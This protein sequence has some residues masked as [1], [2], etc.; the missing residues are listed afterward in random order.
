MSILAAMPD[1]DDEAKLTRFTNVIAGLDTAIHPLEERWM[2][3]SSPRMTLHVSNRLRHVIPGRAKREPG[4]HNHR[5]RVEAQCDH[6]F[7][8]RASAGVMDSG[9]ALLRSASRNDEI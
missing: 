7:A 9:P 4:I 2:R 3:G 6:R 5:H 1:R 8:Q